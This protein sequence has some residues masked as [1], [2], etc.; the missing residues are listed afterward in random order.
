MPACCSCMP[1]SC[2]LASEQA[3]C[4]FR[5]I[6]VVVMMVMT[7]MM[8]IVVVVVIITTT[9]LSRRLVLPRRWT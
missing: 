4:S 6:I 9:V 7:M 8:M 1:H 5:V 3:S 2:K